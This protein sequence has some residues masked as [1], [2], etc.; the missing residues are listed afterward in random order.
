MFFLL[1]LVIFSFHGRNFRFFGNSEELF[2]FDGYLVIS[3]HPFFAVIWFV[4]QLKQPIKDGCSEFQV[5][6]MIKKKCE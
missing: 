1:N 3:N 6:K 2:V 4:I 5:V